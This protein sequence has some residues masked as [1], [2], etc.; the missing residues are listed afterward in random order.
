GN[1]EC[2]EMC[3]QQTKSF[4]SLSFLYL[5]TGN[6]E[7]LSKMLKIAEVRGDLNAVVHNSLF[8][9]DIEERVRMLAMAGQ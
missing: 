1:I 6:N 7:K 4:S 8:T 9:C 2:V 3:Y 5:L